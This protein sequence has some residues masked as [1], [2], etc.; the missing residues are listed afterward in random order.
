MVM[1]Y[2]GFGYGFELFSMF[3][4]NMNG[5]RPTFGTSFDRP[6]F[7][8]RVYRFN[9]RNYDRM[10]IIDPGLTSISERSNFRFV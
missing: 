7:F 10:G 3:A 4:Q 1:T 5:I 6:S 8:A 9:I 2:F